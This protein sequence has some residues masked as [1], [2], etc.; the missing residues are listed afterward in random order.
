MIPDI[1]EYCIHP[2][3]TQWVVSHKDWEEK[4]DDWGERQDWW[5]WQWQ[6]EAAEEEDYQRRITVET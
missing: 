5:E 6:W 2:S 3:A 1:S 4:Q